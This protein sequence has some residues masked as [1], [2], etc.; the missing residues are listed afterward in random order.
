MNE[1]RSIKKLL[2]AVLCGYVSL[3]GHSEAGEPASTVDESVKK[4]QEIFRSMMK[5]VLLENVETV[6]GIKAAQDAYLHDHYKDY[7]FRGGHM[8]GMFKGLYIQSIGVHNKKGLMQL[9]S[10]DMTAIYKK[11]EKSNDEATRKK[12]RELMRRHGDLEK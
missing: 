3:A 5:L 11:L 4:E 7:E 1:M 9:V 8:Y 12:V 6:E 2:C 10:F